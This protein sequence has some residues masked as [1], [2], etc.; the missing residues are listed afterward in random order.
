MGVGTNVQDRVTALH[1][2][3]CPWRPSDIRQREG[4]AIR[5]GNQN[6][7]VS[8]YRYLTEGSFDGYTWQ[9]I[10]RKEGMVNQV[11]RGM[12]GLEPGDPVVPTRYLTA[13]VVKESG[14]DQTDI[15]GDAYVDGF[16]TLWGLG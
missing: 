5:Q 6:A 16:K 9:T 1:H 3:D 7:E 11:M 15:F 12:L 8:V 4:R 2:I 13:D 14:T 10:A